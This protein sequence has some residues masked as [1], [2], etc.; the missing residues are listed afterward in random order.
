[1]KRS[2]PRSIGGRSINWSGMIDRS[3]SRWRPTSKR[4]W[5]SEPTPHADPSGSSADESPRVLA[6]D[7]PRGDVQVGFDFAFDQAGFSGVGEAGAEADLLAV[8]EG[9]EEVV[10]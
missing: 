5:R 8:G 9:G 2:R 4:G 1:M 7:R 10:G 3:G 6:H